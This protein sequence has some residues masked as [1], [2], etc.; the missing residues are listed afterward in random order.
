M[1]LS[2]KREKKFTSFKRSTLAQRLARLT[3]ICE[4]MDI[5]V[6]IMVDGFESSGRGYVINDICSKLNPKYYDV[7]VFEN[8]KISFLP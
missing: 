1:K 4:N 2:D 8:M 7:E 3:R 5:A 6:L